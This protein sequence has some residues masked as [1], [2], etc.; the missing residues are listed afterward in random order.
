MLAAPL[1][2]PIVGYPVTQFYDIHT[3]GSFSTAA[4]AVPEP[5]TW[6]MMLIG[7]A[8]VGYAGYRSARKRSMA[9]IAA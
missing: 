8:G 4:G 1:L 2:G 7:F 3:D 9:A 6:A 5:S